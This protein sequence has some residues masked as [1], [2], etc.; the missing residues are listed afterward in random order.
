MIVH[1]LMTT[2]EILVYE[3]RSRGAPS[4][5]EVEC[6]SHAAPWRDLVRLERA[7]KPARG[8]AEL[9][10]LWP[11]VSVIRG[12]SGLLEQRGEGEAL[13]TLTLSAGSVLTYP[14]GM[15]VRMRMRQSLNVTC[16]QVAPALLSETARAMG[17]AGEL[18]CTWRRGDEQIEHIAALLEAEV[19][20]GCPSGRAYGEHL[21]R[22]LAAYLLRSYTGPGRPRHDRIAA[23][24]ELIEANPM[25]ELSILQL[26]RTV[27]L[28]PYHFAR[29]FKRRTGLTPHQYILERRVEEAKRLLRDTGLDLAEIAQRLGFRDQSHFTARFRKVTGATPKRWRQDTQKNKS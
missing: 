3:T 16:L 15:R 19:R 18:M 27:H 9:T 10:L 4:A 21:G 22:A 17:A 29:L 2:S 11:T 14:G 28:S 12:D 8:D 13:Q 1:E 20:S 5:A 26:A 6:S 24:L 25:Q 23:A 7:R